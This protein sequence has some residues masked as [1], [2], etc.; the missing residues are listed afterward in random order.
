MKENGGEINQRI[1]RA[2]SHPLRV[3]ILRHLEDGP[4]GSKRLSDRINEPLS[5]V[6]YHMTVL[7]DC[8]V[9]EL[10]GTR[11][12]RGATEKIFKLKPG[13]VIGSGRWREVPVALRT[14]WAGNAIHG[15]A[16]RA[17]KAIYAG[18]LESREG[19]GL[20]WQALL[21]DRLGWDEIQH[22]LSSAEERFRGVAEESAKRMESPEDGFPVVVAV[23]AFESAGREDL[24]SS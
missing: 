13:D 23:G 19:S 14:Y 7:R 18:T 2:L 1:V 15:F 12:R 17:L 11:Q 22:V 4:T 3:E 20:S 21:V 5:N 10:V 8:G 16:E 6:S 24:G 9:I